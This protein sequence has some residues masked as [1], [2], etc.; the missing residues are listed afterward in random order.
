MDTP[1]TTPTKL[2]EVTTDAPCLVVMVG[3]PGS[4]KS[5]YSGQFKDVYGWTYV[6][7][8]AQGN[9]HLQIFK[10]AVASR[11]HIVV[12]RM[13]FT[14]HQRSRY[15]DLAHENGYQTQIVV[16]HQPY[17]EC[18]E[19]CMAR[20]GHETIKDEK[21]ARSAINMFFS[22]YERV[23]DNEAH[24]VTRIWPEGEKPSVIVCDLDGTLCDVEH[25]R[26]FVK[27]PAGEKKDWVGFF[28]GMA[29]DKPQQ[30]CMDILKKFSEFKQHTIVYCSGRPDNWKKLTMEWLEKYEAPNGYLFMRPRSDSRQD[31][32]VKEIILDF[33]ILTRFTPYFMIDDRKQVVDMWRARGYTCLACAEGD[34]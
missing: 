23:Q 4:G 21:A 12:D 5:T 14:K 8:D 10:D 15:L 18:F 25:R 9:G 33:E 2:P 32:I 13:G 1:T 22:K 27:K 31:N 20:Q 24:H 29:D 17:R 3:P 30:W 6:N 19:R 34:F 26:H 7:Q 28:R 16:L 11:Q